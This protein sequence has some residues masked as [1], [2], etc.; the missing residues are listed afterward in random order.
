MLTRPISTYTIDDELISYSSVQELNP[1]YYRDSDL[2][3]DCLANL[4]NEDPADYSANNQ[5]KDQYMKSPLLIYNHCYVKGVIESAYQL[6]L[7]LEQEAI[8]MHAA[9]GNYI[10]PMAL[11]VIDGTTA[12]RDLALHELKIQFIEAGIGEEEIKIKGNFIDELDGVDV[13]APDC[14][15]RYVLTVHDAKKQW[16]CPF[17]YVLAALQSRAC[18]I[19]I[20][21]T[22]YCVLPQPGSTA[23][24]FPLLNTAYVLMA[25]SK[26]QEIMTTLREHLNDLGMS[27]NEMHIKDDLIKLLRHISVFEILRGEIGYGLEGIDFRRGLKES[28]VVKEMVSIVR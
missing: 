26:F 15:V 14:K 18:I 22:V 28:E 27:A 1:G 12:L 23:T 3:E 5:K 17:V 4:V 24:T 9:G 16:R 19:D 8:A 10:R 2:H 7:R 21:N 13:L 11:F 20:A 6:R 25:S